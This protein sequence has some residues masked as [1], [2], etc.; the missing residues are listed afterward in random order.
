[1]VVAAAPVVAGAVV[2]GNIVAPAEKPVA[3]VEPDPPPAAPVVAGAGVDDNN[4]APNEK[5]PGADP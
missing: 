3:T 2:D 1:M 4:V 5:L